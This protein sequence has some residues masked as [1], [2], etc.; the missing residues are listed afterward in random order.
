MDPNEAPPSVDGLRRTVVYMPPPSHGVDSYHQALDRMTEQSWAATSSLPTTDIGYYHARACPI[1]YYCHSAVNARQA[2]APGTA[3][4]LT[5]AA[6]FPS[7]TLGAFDQ[8]GQV[9]PH[10]GGRLPGPML[11]EVQ[12][13][14]GM[15]RVVVKPGWCTPHVHASASGMIAWHH[16]KS[17]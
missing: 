4:V 17:S 16:A 14:K 3:T 11:R 1:G 12:T 6:A 13:W 9:L 7:R 8:D 15:R 5:P 2:V 10:S